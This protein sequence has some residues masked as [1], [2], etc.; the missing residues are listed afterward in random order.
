MTRNL[1]IRALLL[2]FAGGFVLTSCS[3]EET[4]SLSIKGSDTV[5]PLSQKLAE[6]FMNRHKD[7]TVTVVG[8]GSGVGIAALIDGHTDIANA[9]RSIKEKEIKAAQ[10]KG[11]NP[12]KHTIAKDG[13]TVVVHPDNPVDSLTIEQISAI[14]DGTISNWSEVGGND[15]AIVV[16]SRENS[17][18]T[19]V[20]FK[21]AVLGDKEYRQ[22][23]NLMPSTGAI[24]SAIGQTPGAIGYIGIAY[25]N[26]K[27]KGLV[28]S[29]DGSTWAEPTGENVMN[30][31]Y[32]LARGLFQ[33]ASDHAGDGITKLWYDFVFS[34]D[35]QKIVSQVGYIPVK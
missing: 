27:T 17:S 26:D 29:Q 9:S 24:T 16:Y 13:I 25:L 5:L 21:E 22:D 28:I 23:A 19:Y 15:E 7:Y 2:M 6:E 20:Y 10:A 32:P 14:Y 31:S 30:G 35:G 3:K 18:G 1:F 4:K 12:V 8:G 34:A 11:I 33:Y